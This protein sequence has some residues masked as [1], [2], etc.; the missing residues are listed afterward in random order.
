MC[1]ICV[2]C[3]VCARVPAGQ[4]DAER[5]R[6]VCI[7]CIGEWRHLTC[8]REESGSRET[9]GAYNAERAGEDWWAYYGWRVVWTVEAETARVWIGRRGN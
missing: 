8:P 1:E 3:V 9:V 6:R 5:A 7:F 2:C 4:S